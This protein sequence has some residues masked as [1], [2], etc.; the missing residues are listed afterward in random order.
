MTNASSNAAEHYDVIIVGAGLSGVC[1]AWHL[2]KHRPQDRVLVIEARDSVGGT[3]DL[4][5]YPGV[6][7][8]SDM[9]TLGYAFRPWLERDSI[10][11]GERIRH[12]IEQTARD[13]GLLERIRFGHK[14][15]RAD[16]SS[17][18]GMWTL[19]AQTADGEQ[20]LHTRFL[21]MCTGYYDYDQGHTPDWPG[22]EQFEGPVVHPQHWPRDLDWRNKHVAV[23]GSGATA[24]T[25]IPSLAEDARR[26]T[27]VQR[28]PT[29]I[30]EMPARDALARWCHRHLGPTL[31]HWLTRWKNILYTMFTYQ[32]SRRFPDFMRRQLLS[33]VREAVG[34]KL[35]VD[36]HFSPPYKPWDQ[37]LCLAPDGDFFAA[38]RAGR[39]DVAT[40]DIQS[41]D[42]SG[43]TLQDGMRVDAD[44]LVTA[45][46]L[47]L[48]V[49]GGADLYVDGQRVRA[50]RR[51]TYKGA[52][53]SGVPNLALTMGYTNASW[54]LKCELI[55]QWVVRLRDHM[56]S[57]G[58]SV[59][60]PRGPSAR[61]DRPFID[62][63]AGY[64]RRADHLL[65]R[66]SQAHPWR[67]NQN[68]FQDLRAFRWS[69]IDDGALEFL[70]AGETTSWQPAREAGG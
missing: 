18:L 29:Y 63:D 8:D 22:L 64:I 33:Q 24:V 51:T 50:A 36:K 23:I 60:L 13:S 47:S 15:A 46:G 4:F 53:L 14:L 26:V 42:A 55:A 62:L 2:Q 27:M 69:R 25:L 68:Y 52:M 61:G 5:R 59:V 1:A 65:P 20:Q 34:G 58:K 48:K 11:H 67:V 16:W 30:A 35:D 54:T 45:T 41:I 28:T 66:Q 7:S 21:M 57:A 6:R 43:L 40:G 3:W 70:A 9:P 38:I 31:A 19:H 39:V 44:I 12:Y 49:A 56:E 37:R 17:D 10:A 32:L